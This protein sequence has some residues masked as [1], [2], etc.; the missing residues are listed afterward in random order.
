MFAQV[1]GCDKNGVL[2]GFQS[3][4]MHLKPRCNHYQPLQRSRK[5]AMDLSKF[6]YTSSLPGWDGYWGRDRILE[7][8]KALKAS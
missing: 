7:Y 3:I 1:R 6:F 4:Q 2:T 5:P 8:P